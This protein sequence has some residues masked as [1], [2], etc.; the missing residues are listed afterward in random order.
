MRHVSVVAALAEL[1]EQLRRFVTAKFP[2]LRQVSSLSIDLRLLRL[3]SV[4]AWR[5]LQILM[6]RL[7]VKVELPRNFAD[8]HSI[9]MQLLY[10]KEVLQARIT[11][12]LGPECSGNA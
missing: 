9:L 10:L 1:A 7:S 8:G 2:P 5:L 4:L 12:L 3:P 11:T 6:N